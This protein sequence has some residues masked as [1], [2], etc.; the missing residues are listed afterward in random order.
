[1]VQIGAEVKLHIFQTSKAGVAELKDGS[2]SR[3]PEEQPLES[4][5]IKAEWIR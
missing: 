4:S 2:Q 5:G 3:Y 1:M